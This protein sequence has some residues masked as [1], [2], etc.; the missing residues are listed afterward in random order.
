[1]SVFL[2]VLAGWGIA[3]Y[4]AD[5]RYLLFLVL[6]FGTVVVIA[7]GGKKSLQV[8]FMI[9][10]WMF[11]LGYRTI[12]LTSS[13][14]LHPLTIMLGLLLV[15]WLFLLKS[16]RVVQPRLPKLLWLFSIFWL[17]GFI[18][19]IAHGYPLSRMLSDALN[20]VCLIP[21]FMIILYLARE[22]GFWKSATI[23][24]LLAGALISFLG[25]L[26][27]Y[28]PQFRSL[29]PGLIET[30][31]EGIGSPSSEFL[32]ASFAIFGANPA[33]LIC[34]LALPMVW[35]VPKFYQNKIA[36]FISFALIVVLGIGIYI[37]GTRDA[38]LMTL[39]TSLLLAYFW[40][41]WL[42][43]AINRSLLECCQSVPA[44]RCLEFDIFGNQATS[45]R[46]DH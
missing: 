23:S 27:Y 4:G 6:L 40:M 41:K 13:F 2:S 42:G 45:F 38:W 29:L 35:L 22:P 30:N 39:V 32:R 1:M 16:E 19:G 24:F 7:L 18:P 17:W 33:V 8:G 20:F 14:A 21:L 3:Y 36:S 9:W 11:I 10:T 44:G 34:A 26:E 12:H 46:S 31:V 5:F 28:S 37:S 15:I 25:T 43:L